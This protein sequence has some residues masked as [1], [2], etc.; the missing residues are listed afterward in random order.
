MCAVDESQGER[1][2]LGRVE[3]LKQDNPLCELI[4]APAD[5]VDPAITIQDFID[6]DSCDRGSRSAYKDEDTVFERPAVFEVG[7]QPE[8]LLRFVT[9]VEEGYKAVPYHNS[10]HAACVTHGV[11]HVR[12]AVS[13][14]APLSLMKPAAVCRPC[15]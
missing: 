4:R 3:G 6:H 8:A 13:I 14:R 7:F 12:H 5:F 11:Y 10:A 15:Y 2:F 1:V 9:R